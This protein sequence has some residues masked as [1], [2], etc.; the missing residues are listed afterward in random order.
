[1]TIPYR[2]HDSDIGNKKRGGWGWGVHIRCEQYDSEILFNT[3]MRQAL[4]VR[5]D[6][7]YGSFGKG[8]QSDLKQKEKG[9]GSGILRRGS[10]ISRT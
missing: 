10:V 2:V 5:K 3:N 4:H 9:K 6:K 8:V 7:Q 1:M